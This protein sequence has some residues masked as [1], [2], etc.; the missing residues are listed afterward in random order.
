MKK[1]QYIYLV[2]NRVL[3]IR[4]LNYTKVFKNTETLFFRADLEAY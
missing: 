3:T 4:N 1:Q 2:R